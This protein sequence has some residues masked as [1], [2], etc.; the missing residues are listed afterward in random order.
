[1]IDFNKNKIICLFLQM[2]CI[3]Y[4]SIYWKIKGLIIKMHMCVLGPIAE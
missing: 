2:K 4:L 3:K 1:M